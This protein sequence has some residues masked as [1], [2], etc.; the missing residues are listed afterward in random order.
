MAKLTPPELDRHLY[1]KLRNIKKELKQDLLTARKRIPEE[2]LGRKES[3]C[4]QN[5]R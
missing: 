2:T 5:Q 1:N 3:S 4:L